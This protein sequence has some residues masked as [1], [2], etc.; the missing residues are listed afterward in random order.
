M[1]GA[2]LKPPDPIFLDNSMY[3]CAWP[4]C[5][6]LGDYRSSEQGNEDKRNHSIPPRQHKPMAFEHDTA[7]MADVRPRVRSLMM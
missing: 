7:A 5:L 2:I 4:G 3:S 1:S 6:R